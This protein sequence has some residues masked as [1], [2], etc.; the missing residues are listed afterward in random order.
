MSDSPTF[1]PPGLYAF[2]YSVVVPTPTGSR[3]EI[4][5]GMTLRDYFAA[6]VVAAYMRSVIWS[7]AR[8]PMANIA[9]YSYEMADAMLK[10]REGET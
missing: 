7:E 1:A 6:S 2:P 10:A 3:F 4:C 9:R 5:P 8:E